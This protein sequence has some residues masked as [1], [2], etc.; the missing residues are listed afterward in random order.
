MRQTKPVPVRVTVI[1]E[2]PKKR[3]LPKVELYFDV[4]DG[5]YLFPFNG[6]FIPM[7]K[8]EIRD[9]HLK[10]MGFTD[11]LY[12]N[13]LREIDMPFVEAHDFRMI[14][15]SGAL[16]GHRV[17]L[18][19]DSARSYLVTEEAS[20]VWTDYPK[21]Q[22]APEWFLKFIQEL[23]Q[24]GQSDHFLYWLKS[25]LESLRDGDFRPGQ[26]VVFAG[27]SGCGKSLVQLIVTEVLGG[28]SAD[29]FRYM[30]GETQFNKDLSAAEHWMIQDPPTTT[31]IR[32]RRLFGC[33]LKECTVNRDFSIHQKGKD[34]LSLPIFRRVT[35]S[36][37]D[38]PENLAVVPPM[39]PSIVDKVFLFKCSKA[40]VGSDRKAT[41]QT[42]LKEVPLIRA[43]LLRMPPVPDAL[44]CDRFG[45][46]SWHH[47]DLLAEL[48]NLSAEN[49]LLSVID[50]V[51][52]PEEADG[53]AQSTF[54]VKSMELEKQIRASAY[55]FAV[56]KLLSYSGACGSLL[57]KL[58]K[59]QPE[60]VQKVIRDGV[61][62]WKIHRPQI[63]RDTAE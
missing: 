50:Q 39:D 26:V 1:K 27:E 10:R 41:W 45:I 61:T 20:G 19:K 6:R 35:I 11:Q 22:P 49:R 47:S 7:K 12:E 37:N 56:E 5:S 58:S 46:R 32:T 3:E 36:V 43:F 59:S 60:R 18:L 38:E 33:K 55:G 54:T 57:G 4:R 8:G 42:I 52:L 40:N 63:E 24:D 51:L 62:F 29:P 16:A 17:G 21:R 25:S 30:M 31:D 9:L 48:S 13:G 14:D 23:L 28:R 44:R 15:Y 2:P 53:I 34:A